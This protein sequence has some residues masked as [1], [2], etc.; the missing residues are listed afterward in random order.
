M[1]NFSTA[2]RTTGPVN[3]FRDRS[4]AGVYL[5]NLIA[6]SQSPAGQ[7]SAVPPVVLALPRGGVPIAFAIARALN[8]PLDLLLVRKLGI[9]GCD[10]VAMGAAVSFFSFAAGNIAYIDTTLIKNLNIPQSEYR[11][12]KHALDVEGRVV[13]LVDDG[14][15][16]GATMLIVVAPVGAPE[17]CADI[18]KIADQVIV[19]LQPR[20]FNAVGLWYDDF[21]QTDD[22][23]VLLLLDKAKLFGAGP[24]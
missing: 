19:P 1:L 15:A 20:N 24:R 17:S 13:Y 16:T 4:H 18:S 12:G 14:I 9:P 7:T 11:S 3:Q 5:A 2:S 10:E 23:E 21:P 22:K 8:A 6:D